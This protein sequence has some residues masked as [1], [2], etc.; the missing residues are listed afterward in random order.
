MQSLTT[1]KINYISQISVMV[2]FTDRLIYLLVLSS[3]HYH[4]DL[5]S[6]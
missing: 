4:T 2:M 5:S 1:L 6:N 3:V